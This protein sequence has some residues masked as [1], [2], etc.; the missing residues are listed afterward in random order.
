[1]LDQLIEREGGYVNH[2]ADRGGPTKYGITAKTL[3]IW[4]GLNRAAT[5]AEVRA[6][7]RD[8]AKAIY[9]ARYLKPFECV[10]VDELRAQLFDFAVNAGPRA[11]IVALQRILKVPVDG[12]LGPRTLAAVI[13]LPWR[14]VNNKLVAERLNHYADIVADDIS[15]VVFFRGW[16]ARAVDF[17]V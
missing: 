14:D 17:I 4:L 9:R 10:P 7:T 2:S 15:Q 6:L 8:E 13:A 12:I 11:A 1:M 5:I 16:I 3:G